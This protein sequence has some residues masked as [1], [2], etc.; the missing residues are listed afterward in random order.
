MPSTE[1]KSVLSADFPHVRACDVAVLSNPSLFL[2]LHCAS[3]WLL[4]RYAHCFSGCPPHAVNIL[5]Y[6]SV[7]TESLEALC[8]WTDKEFTFASCTELAWF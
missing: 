4:D 7:P 6:S 1:K 8:G 2:F 3:V 5:L